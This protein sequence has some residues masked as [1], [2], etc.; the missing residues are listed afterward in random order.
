VL[1]NRH[2]KLR[3]QDWTVYRF[4]ER[5]QGPSVWEA[6]HVV[7]WSTAGDA[8]AGEPLHAVVARPSCARSKTPIARRRPSGP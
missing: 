4:D 7:F 6:K 5:E 1:L 3:D 2:P 8:R